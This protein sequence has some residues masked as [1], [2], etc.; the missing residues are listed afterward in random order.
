MIAFVLP[1]IAMST[2]IAL[3]KAAGVRT[4]DGLGPPASAIATAR[5]PDIS[6]SA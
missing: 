6:A 5:R 1:A 2:R 3:S 4:W